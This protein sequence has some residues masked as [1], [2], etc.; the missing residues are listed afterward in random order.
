MTH[1]SKPVQKKTTHP[2]LQQHKLLSEAPA[3]AGRLG[4][5]QQSRRPKALSDATKD[6]MLS[7]L[8]GVE[9]SSEPKP[10]D[11]ERQCALERV[12]GLFDLDGSGTI[13]AA[14]LME[15]GQARRRL[16]QKGGEWTEEKNQRLVEKLGGSEDGQV[17][18]VEFVRHFSSTLAHLRLSEF[19]ATIGAFE[20]AAAACSAGKQQPEGKSGA[21]LRSGPARPG[22]R[23]STL[24]AP[25]VERKRQRI[26]ASRR[27]DCGR[28]TARAHIVGEWCESRRW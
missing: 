7:R 12:F 8:E 17:R 28:A 22:E 23:G 9:A 1:G 20:Q 6:D 19:E 24:V 2:A 16:G 18:C 21:G 4:E 11:A 14:E 25:A 27:V 10:S 26:Q 15:L 13:E 5:Q 3:T